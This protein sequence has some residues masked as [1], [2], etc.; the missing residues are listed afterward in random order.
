MHKLQKVDKDYNVQE[1]ASE[2]KAEALKQLEA[3][4]I[5]KAE[6]P[7]IPPELK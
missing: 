6:N 3:D 2:L 7:P 4:G 1:R 5:I